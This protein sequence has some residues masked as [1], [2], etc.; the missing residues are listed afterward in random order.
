M[1]VMNASLIR[2]FV[3]GLALW[4]IGCVR[5]VSREPRFGFSSLVGDRVTLREDMFLT[6]GSRYVEFGMLPPGFAELPR[7]VE[8]YEQHRPGVP[9][10]GIFAVVR[11]GVSLRIYQLIN[12]DWNSS[13]SLHAFAR[14]LDG[15]FEGKRVEITSLLQSPTETMGSDW[16]ID[17]AHLTSGP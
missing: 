2:S 3:I 17:P 12:D 9:T 11:A 1:Q 7:S 15:P 13:S 4:S 16:R 6:R 10:D 14:F 8:E 5:D